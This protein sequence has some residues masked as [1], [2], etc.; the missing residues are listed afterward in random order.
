LT[1]LGERATPACRKALEG[2]RALEVRRRIEAILDEQLHDSHN[3]TGDP[4][5]ALRAFEILEIAG[6]PAACGVLEAL[7]RGA[8]EARLTQE[9]RGSLRRLKPQSAD[10]Q[11]R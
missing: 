6:G 4:L 11:S 7:S 10:A 5:R 9:A 2:R 1:N 3:P 8:P